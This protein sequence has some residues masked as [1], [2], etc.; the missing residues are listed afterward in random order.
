MH[1]TK[2]QWVT[3]GSTIGA[4]LLTAIIHI[5]IREWYQPD[6]RYEEGSWYRAEQTAVGS[7]KLHN[8]GHSDATS[9][10]ISASFEE[11]IVNISTSDPA[12][13]F[14]ILSEGMNK[15]SVTGEIE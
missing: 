14:N 10:R 8:F 13:N 12:V 2:G 7:L 4:V 15:N 11:K 5:A 1:L 9:I 3:L 6:V